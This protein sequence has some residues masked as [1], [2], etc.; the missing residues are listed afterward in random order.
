MLDVIRSRADVRITF[1]DSNAS[2]HAIALPA[3]L[4]RGLRA[5]FFVVAGRLD[6]EGYLN[7]EQVRSL[8]AAG[9]QIGSHGM[10]HQRWV[11]LSPSGSALE[12][13]GTKNTLENL[14]EM[15]VLDAACPFGS[16]DRR[17]LS[18]LRHAGFATVY[19]SDGCRADS[20]AWLQPRFSLRRSQTAAD[21]LSL[22]SSSPGPLRRAATASKLCFKR[23]R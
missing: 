18:Q 10:Y 12:I 2:D 3:L 8:V 14:V 13:Q 15:P 5:K 1:D 9:M 21:L 23:W 16:Y 7:R 4:D 19:T 20:A 6:R 11:G 22:L 17:T